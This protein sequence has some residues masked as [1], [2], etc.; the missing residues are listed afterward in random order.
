MTPAA[1]I[2][3]LFL[4]AVLLVWSALFSGLET[5]LFSL[6][7]HQLRRLEEKHR[8]LKD[9]ITVFRENP[10]QVLNVL[11]LGDVFANVPLIVLCLFFIWQGPL[12]GRISTWLA[13]TVIFAIVVV[14]CDLIPKLL[15][16]SAP[17]RLSALG[18]FTLK[19]MMPLLDRVGRVLEA[20]STAIVDRLTPVHLQKRMRLSD[21]ELETLVEIGEEQGTLHEAEGEMIQEIIKLGDKTAKDCMTPRVD[22]F[23]LPDDLTNE[24]AIAQLRQR[25]HRRVP[26][27]ADTP[28]QIVGV[29]DV[30]VFL[31]NPGDHY[32]EL[33]GAPSYVAETMK[34]MDLL[35][36]FLTHSQGLAIVVDEYGGTEGIITLSDIVEEIISD[37]APLGDADLYIEPLEDGRFLVSGNARL[38]DLS[39]HLGFELEAEG[40]DTIGGLL[41]NRLGYLPPSG[42]R[43]EMPRLAVTIRRAGRKRIEEILLEKTACL[44]PDTEGNGAT[45]P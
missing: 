3:F 42:T 24:E 30:K 6:K 43:F 44:D 41:F 14:V 21:E 23:A 28:D 7:S 4:I 35:R 31:V 39:E 16:L 15:A 1:L 45:H 12:A 8:S 32:T 40:L 11:L 36:S 29:L 25:R 17:Y 10:R 19:T 38:D 20:A 22:T 33:M 9:F 2:V 13:A 26:V 18:V 37:A 27:Y 34:A 5:A